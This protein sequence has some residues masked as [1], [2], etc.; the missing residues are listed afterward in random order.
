MGCIM[1]DGFT[2]DPIFLIWEGDAGR[3]GLAICKGGAGVWYDRGTFPECNVNDPE[4][5]GP[6]VRLTGV[7][8][9]S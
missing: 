1:V 9:F 6:C 3:G 4:F 7:T 2:L 8:V 5:F